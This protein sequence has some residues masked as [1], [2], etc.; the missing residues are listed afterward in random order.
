M[1]GST[2]LRQQWGK[3]I[4]NHTDNPGGFSECAWKKVNKTASKVSLSKNV[5]VDG[6]YLKKINNLLLLIL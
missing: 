1:D 6:D 3:A 4:E 2:Q 5:V